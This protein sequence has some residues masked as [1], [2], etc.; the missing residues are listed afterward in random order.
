LV[1]ATSSQAV[2]LTTAC[3]KGR[4]GG[5][6]AASRSIIDGEIA[7]S[8]ALTP[9]QDLATR[10]ADLMSRLLLAQVR[11]LVQQEDQ[12]ATRDELLRGGLPPEGG[13]DSHQEIFWE[14]RIIGV[15]QLMVFVHY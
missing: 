4:K 2:A 5:L 15:T 7:R 9:A 11:V 6:E 8:P 13:K 12:P 10:E 1:W 3:S 14:S